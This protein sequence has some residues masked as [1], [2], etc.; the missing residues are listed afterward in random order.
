MKGLTESLWECYTSSSDDSFWSLQ[1]HHPHW[2]IHTWPLSPLP[3]PIKAEGEFSSELDAF[4]PSVLWSVNMVL[5]F[6][7]AINNQC[8]KGGG[9][10]PSCHS[11][12][13]FSFYPARISYKHAWNPDHL[14]VCAL[15]MFACQS[16]EHWQHNS[17]KIC[18]LRSKRARK[19]FMKS[20]VVFMITPEPPMDITLI[21]EMCGTQFNQQQQFNNWMPQL[22]L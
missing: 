6:A 13:V 5:Y 9:R 21:W 18:G 17:F 3:G 1:F 7:A 10:T 11:L 19:G 8:D 20:M 16:G 4:I 2:T 15:S 14:W 22:D 12:S